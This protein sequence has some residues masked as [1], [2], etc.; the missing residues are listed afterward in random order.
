VAC[1][2][3][4]KRGLGNATGNA[5]GLKTLKYAEFI[6]ELRRLAAQGDSLIVDRCTHESRAFRDWRHAVQN[7]VSNA[8]NI[9]SNLPGTFSSSARMY[10]AN[11]A[12]PT[13]EENWKAFE[14]DVGD[15]LAEL[16]F[17]IDQF[18]KY[19]APSRPSHKEA[20]KAPLTAPEKVTVRWLVDNV[21][22]VLWAAFAGVLLA[23]FSLGFTFGQFEFSRKLI[24]IF[25]GLFGAS[26]PPH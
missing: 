2:N 21:P 9:G 6:D 23:T 10:R 8:N 3:Q 25:L 26:P 12:G 7:T 20:A 16:R 22:V 5:V 17:L 18:D 4:L 13:A 14:R 1:D 11:W 19:G 24:A 15:S